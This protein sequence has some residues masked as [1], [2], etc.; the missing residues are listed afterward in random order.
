MLGIKA[1]QKMGEDAQ[2]RA[3]YNR[4]PVVFEIT[5]NRNT[6]DH[7]YVTAQRC[8]LGVLGVLG[9]RGVLGVLKCWG[10]Y[11]KRVSSPR[12]CLLI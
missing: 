2:V 11:R 5:V 7:P 6:P 12:I 3:L 9:V 4:P 1:L 10:C 8:A